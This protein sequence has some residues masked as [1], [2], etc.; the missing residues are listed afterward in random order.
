MAVIF[1]LPPKNHRLLLIFIGAV[2]PSPSYLQR[3]KYLFLLFFQN[4]LK[5]SRNALRLTI[6]LIGLQP[7]FSS[8]CEQFNCELFFVHS[9]FV[10]KRGYQNLSFSIAGKNR[11]ECR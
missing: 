10:H 9:K 5:K 4:S 2:C 11:D 6:N 1:N 7:Q 8:I 3:L